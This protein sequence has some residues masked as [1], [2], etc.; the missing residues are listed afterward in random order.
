[1]EFNVVTELVGDI[2]SATIKMQSGIMKDDK[3]YFYLLR[4][5]RVIFRLESWISQP[6]YHWD[7]TESGVYTVQAH[8]KRN[9]KNT[10]RKS[11]P[12]L[13]LQEEKNDEFSRWLTKYSCNTET[14]PKL[15]L[16]KP[17]E[18]YQRFCVVSCADGVVNLPSIDLDLHATRYHSCNSIVFSD[19]ELKIDS[20]YESAFSGSFVS[21]K[22]YY[23]GQDELPSSEILIKNNQI[24]SYSNV[25]IEKR[26]KQLIISTDYFGVNKIFYF[27][28]DGIFVASN[29]YHLLIVILSKLG[30]NL[31]LDKGKAISKLV[32][33]SLQPF[34]QNYSSEMDIQ[35]IFVLSVDKKIVIRNGLVTFVD[36]EIAKDINN[37]PSYDSVNYLK[38]LEDAKGEIIGNLDAV[39]NHSRFNTAILDLSGGMDS[40]IV[41][42]AAT[43]LPQHKEKIKINSH[44][45]AAEPKDLV[46]FP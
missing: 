8:V 13:Y 15:E 10:L 18:P 43:N 36:S 32:F 24:G 42:A 19:K 6:K 3:F 17:Q 14:I 4:D 33:I 21:E 37:P 34:H 38:L 12:T 26:K 45:V 39:L 16:Y 30:V 46:H 28:R 5:D 23:F 44:Y 41:Y 27:R 25:T 2:Y 29:N 31:S 9:S 40:R 11:I 22:T 35:D 1:M 20:L 7:L